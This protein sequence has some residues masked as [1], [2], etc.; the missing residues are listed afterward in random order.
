MHAGVIL[1]V[2]TT[3]PIQWEV[4]EKYAKQKITPKTIH[5]VAV[6]LVFIF[7]TVFNQYLKIKKRTSQIVNIAVPAEHRV[8]VKLSEERD[9][10]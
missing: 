8:K 10:Y 1:A 6:N 4:T 3:L 5:A 9:K 2:Y 7:I